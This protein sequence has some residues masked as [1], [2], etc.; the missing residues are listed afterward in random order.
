MKAVVCLPTK[1][2][3]LSVARMVQAIRSLGLEVFLV[4]E[5]ST[6]QTAAIAAE[7]GVPVFQRDGHGKGWGVRKAVE[8]AAARGDDVLVLI[9]CDCSYDPADIPRVLEAM[10]HH[11]TVIGRRPMCE[12][13]WPHRLVNYL[14]TGTVNMLFGARLHDI[15]SGLRALR[16]RA[17]AQGLTAEGFDI[18]AQLTTSALRRG[19]SVAEAPVHYHKRVGRSKIRAWDTVNILRRI[20]TEWLLCV[21]LP[22]VSFGSARWDD[23]QQ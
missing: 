19:L 7:H 12:I 5:R 13:S 21:K 15:N 17:Y 16:V 8:V 18:E 11:A 2:E 22:R 23:L 1:N 6:D 9:D 20:F 14:H 4:D 10:E 3:A